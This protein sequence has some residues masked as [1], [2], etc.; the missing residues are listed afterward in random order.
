MTDLSA[1]LFADIAARDS[2]AVKA[3]IDRADEIP[4]FAARFSEEALRAGRQYLAD[5]QILTNQQLGG[6]GGRGAPAAP[7]G[8]GFGT[9]VYQHLESFLTQLSEANDAFGRTMVEMQAP[10]VAERLAER[11][12]VQAVTAATPNTRRFVSVRLVVRATMQWL[13]RNKWKLAA[14]ITVVALTVY[15]YSYLNS[16][17]AEN[18][19]KHEAERKQLAEQFAEQLD[20]YRNATQWQLEAQ[21]QQNAQE[22]SRLREHVGI[23]LE[24]GQEQLEGAIERVIE[25]EHENN[26]LRELIVEN[27]EEIR[28][29]A[30]EQE[31][32]G[33]VLVRQA[34]P[35]GAELTTLRPFGET[36]NTMVEQRVEQVINERGLVPLNETLAMVDG[37]I[38][39]NSWMTST[40]NAFTNFFRPRNVRPYYADPIAW[41]ET[42]PVQATGFK[43]ARVH[44]GSGGV[45]GAYQVAELDEEDARL[46][47]TFRDLPLTD[48]AVQLMGPM[49]AAMALENVWR[50]KEQVLAAKIEGVRR[51]STPTEVLASASAPRGT[52]FPELAT[53]ATASLRDEEDRQLAEATRRSLSLYAVA[54][55]QSN[56][57]NSYAAAAADDDVEISPE[58]VARMRRRLFS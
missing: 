3:K 36:L 8:P 54:A 5:N 17:M 46:L 23:A 28:Q 13:Q 44:H 25:L 42:G 49:I 16:M 58:E 33:E 41:D 11:D 48:R 19:A 7:A 55:E 18:D 20:A 24:A 12:L 15:L 32:I 27:S 21:Q 51:S 2:S 34:L 22:V 53:A 52:A 39:E 35:Q 43:R 38:A 40:W 47:A 45:P 14:G 29:I 6:G 30:V 31:V 1:A 4:Q 50:D 57:N 37:R 56:N 9:R 26:M 10:H